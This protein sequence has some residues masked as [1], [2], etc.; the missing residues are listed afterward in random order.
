MRGQRR[1]Y[2]TL[3]GKTWGGY[4]GAKDIAVELPR[5]L[6]WKQVLEKHGGDFEWCH[7]LN[8]SRV[9]LTRTKRR[10]DLNGTGFVQRGRSYPITRFPSARLLLTD[11]KEQ[12]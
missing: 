3:Y 1:L 8:T 10:E 11:G 9:E 12:V 7:F 5:P 2:G 6:R 4:Y